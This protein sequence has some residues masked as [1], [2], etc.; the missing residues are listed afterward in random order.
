MCIIVLFE[1][2]NNSDGTLRQQECFT[3]SVSC[4]RV[5]LADPMPHYVT[6][7]VM[8]VNGT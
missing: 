1:F 4:Y 7:T 5:Q 2:W 8:V 3:G 6:V